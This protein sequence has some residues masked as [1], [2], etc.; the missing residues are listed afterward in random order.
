MDWESS[1]QCVFF[2]AP[3]SRY[4]YLDR[5]PFR[6]R[7]RNTTGSLIDDAKQNAPSFLRPYERNEN[8][9]ASSATFHTELWDTYALWYV[10]SKSHDSESV[11]DFF[12]GRWIRKPSYLVTPFES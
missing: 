12:P 8:R 10:A 6:T 5:D 1:P 11:R 2:H 7:V 3:I 9:P 4:A